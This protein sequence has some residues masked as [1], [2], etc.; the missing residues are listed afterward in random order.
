MI[1]KLLDPS[2]LLV[3]PPYFAGF[4][5]LWWWEKLLQIGLCGLHTSLA[6]HPSG[7]H[8]LL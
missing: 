6:L 4:W 8:M 5:E 3:F 1:P 7:L 2:S